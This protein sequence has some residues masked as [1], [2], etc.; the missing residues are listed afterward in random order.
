LKLDPKRLTVLA[1]AIRSGSMSQA[2]LELGYSTAAVSQHIGALER[3]VGAALLVRHARGVRATPAGTLLATH[4]HAIDDRLAEA[5]RDLAN[6]LRGD[7][8]TIRAGL[9]TSAWVGALPAALSALRRT[10]ADVHVEVSEIDVDIA[11]DRLRAG[12]LG[13]APIAQRSSAAAA[14]RPASSRP[15][16]SR[17]T[18][19]SPRAA[20]SPA[21]WA[22]PPSPGS[23]AS[24]TAP[25][26]SCARCTRH[27]SASSSSPPTPRTPRR[28]RPR[29]D[30]PSCT[31]APLGSLARRVRADTR[32][33]SRART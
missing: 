15:S 25:T 18:T 29:C 1:A 30:T 10:H 22:S 26:S 20:S 5:Q 23:C 16:R 4:A 31:R 12:E 24:R 27:P 8:A 19:T 32:R 28:Q 11:A 2:A 13:T 6:L 33:A 14:W 21:G 17:P 3:E 9:F 7:R